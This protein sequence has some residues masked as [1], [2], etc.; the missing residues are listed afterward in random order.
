MNGE[1]SPTPLL[2]VRQLAMHFPIPE[3]IVLSR[4]IGDVKAVDGVDFTINRGETLGLVGESG[5]GKTTTG[6]CILRLDRHI[7][8]RY[9]FVG[10]DDFRIECQR[11]RDRD[12]LPLPAGK[13]VW[14][15]R[16][17]IGIEADVTQQPGDPIFRFAAAHDTVH[18][19][20]FRNREP[21]G[22]PRIERREWILEDHLDVAA[23]R[24]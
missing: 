22:K 12:A 23:Q 11:A 3:G 14:I 10:D 19:K 24:A 21:D 6:R 20:R 15:T 9:R 18:I 7:E 8:R 17:V 4:K 16:R 13:F 2:E 5:C 1:A